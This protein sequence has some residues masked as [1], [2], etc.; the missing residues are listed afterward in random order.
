MR[1]INTKDEQISEFLL[2]GFA[3]SDPKLL[4]KLRRRQINWRIFKF[5]LSSKRGTGKYSSFDLIGKYN[6]YYYV[7]GM[8]EYL[9]KHLVDLFNLNNPSA[10]PHMKGAFNHKL[11]INYLINNKRCVFK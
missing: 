2:N 3:K 9:I 8:E 5:G 10:P 4:S 1:P 11:R 7:V 6:N